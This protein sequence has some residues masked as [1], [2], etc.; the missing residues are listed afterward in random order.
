MRDRDV[1]KVRIDGFHNLIIVIADALELEIKVV[2]PCD[3]L[4]LRRVARGNDEL[5]LEDSFDDKPAAVMLQSGLT[6]QLVEADMLLLIEPE[7]VFITRRFRLL[8]SFLVGIHSFRLKGVRL[9]RTPG[10]A[11]R[12]PLSDKCQFVGQRYS[13]LPSGEGKD[14]P[15]KTSTEDFGRCLAGVLEPGY[16]PMQYYDSF[17]ARKSRRCGLERTAADIGI[18]IENTVVY[19]DPEQSHSFLKDETRDSKPSFLYSFYKSFMELIWQA[20]TPLISS[21]Q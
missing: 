19:C 7:R 15:P 13:S 16:F 4:H 11:E 18:G 21:A 5:L 6:E 8:C 12:A 20:G 1:G 14:P 17:R 2:E 10:L 3:E 9:G